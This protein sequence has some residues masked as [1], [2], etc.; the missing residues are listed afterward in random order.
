MEVRM[1]TTAGLG[2]AAEV[3]LNGNLLTVCDNLS[4][5]E[6]RCPPGLLERVEFT[7]VCNEARD[8]PQAVADNPAHRRILHSVKGWTYEGFGRVVSLMPTVI[9][10]GLLK[11]EDPD[12]TSD[13]SL[14]GAYVRIPIDRL[15][16]RNAREPD[17][18]TNAR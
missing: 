4:T 8:W 9:D 18:P 6:H 14:L 7:Y 3:W 13:E 11:M 12:W 10:F 5:A 17:W 16:L 1:E 15:E 2:K